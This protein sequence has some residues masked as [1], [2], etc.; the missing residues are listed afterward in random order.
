MPPD[1]VVQ[2]EAQLQQLLAT[3]GEMDEGTNPLTSM[4][5]LQGVLECVR[6]EVET[7]LT[8]AGF[9]VSSPLLVAIFPTGSFNA[10]VKPV[11]GGVLVL[12]HTPAMTLM[13]DMLKV[14]VWSAR[15][16]GHPPRVSKQETVAAVAGLIHRYLTEEHEPPT[17]PPPVNV[18][19]DITMA[20]LWAENPIDRWH[21]YFGP[22]VRSCLRFIVAHEYGHMVAGHIQPNK[23]VVK[24]T[25]VGQVALAEKSHEQEYEADLLAAKI[26]LAHFGQPPQAGQGLFP[27][28]T[29]VSPL[30]FFTMHHAIDRVRSNLGLKPMAVSSDHPPSTERW[31][32]LHS[33]FMQEFSRVGLPRKAV[34]LPE[35]FELWFK[36]IEDDV[37]NT[38]QRLRACPEIAPQ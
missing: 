9:A 22:L 25:P 10:E 33:F 37:I 7:G 15:V 34:D 4:S 23:T 12:I 18:V 19:G 1:F 20:Y 2:F 38:V 6:G 28:A 26:L 31:R 13:A 14:N 24:L 35:A 3:E 21:F 32:R 16:D 5:A 30:F 17:H 8:R 29:L 36:S 11:T 27:A